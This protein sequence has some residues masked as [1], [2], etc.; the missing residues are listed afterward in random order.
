M[1]NKMSIAIFVA[2]FLFQSLAVFAKETADQKFEALA[3]KYIA[4]FLQMN[5]E[6]ATNL[7]EQNMIIGLA[8]TV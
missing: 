5:P 2:L 3:N 7:G 1:F 6:W 8:I 4:E